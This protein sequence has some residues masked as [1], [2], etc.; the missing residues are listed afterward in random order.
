MATIPQTNVSMAAINTEVSGVNSYSLK[1]LSDNATSGSSPK[2]GAPYGMGEFRGY[3]HFSGVYQGAGTST[4]Y[5]D[6]NYVNTSS[7]VLSST[8]ATLQGYSC[9]FGITNVNN[10]ILLVFSSPSGT[11]IW[12]NSGWTTLKVWNNSTGTGTPSLNVNRT[13]FSGTAGTFTVSNNGTS[14]ASAFWTIY[15]YNMGDHFGFGGT[16]AGSPRYVRIT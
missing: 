15:N 2:D 16:S 12:T 7:I 1:T 11:P 5:S 6:G 14:S 4:W 10:S 8:S 3:E 13:S 9:T